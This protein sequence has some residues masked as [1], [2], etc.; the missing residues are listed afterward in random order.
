MLLFVFSIIIG[1][2][3]FLNYNDFDPD[4]NLIDHVMPTE[5]YGSLYYTVD[6]FNDEVSKDELVLVSY[7]IRSFNRNFDSFEAM[8]SSLNVYPNVIVLSET[9]LSDDVNMDGFK[10]FHTFRNDRRSGGV[11]VFCNESYNSEKLDEF[12]I[13]TDEVE[14][15]AIKFEINNTKHIILAIYR[16]HMGT[17]SNFNTRISEIISK[18]A[19]NDLIY[20]VGDLNINLLNLDY[21]EIVHFSTI[22][23]SFYLVPVI[24]EPTRFP[25]ASLNQTPS[26]LDHIWVPINSKISIKSGIIL[27]D[28]TDHCPTF[29]SFPYPKPGSAN[30]KIKLMFRDTNDTNMAIF[31]RAVRDDD[32]DALVPSS[33]D[34]VDNMTEKFIGRLNELYCLC[35]AIK[36]KYVG[37]KRFNKPWITNNNLQKIKEKSKAFKLFKAGLISDQENKSIR[38]RVNILVKHAKKDYFN[39]IFHRCSNDIG[40][41]WKNIRKIIASNKRCGISDISHNNFNYTNHEDISN[42]FSDYF[43]GISQQIDNS[44]PTADESPLR[45]VIPN[46]ISSLFLNPVSNAECSAIIKSLKNKK[47]NV[48]CVSVR[49]VKS[50]SD[51]VSIY[52]SRIVNKSFESGIFPNI[53]KQAIIVPIHKKGVH[54]DVGNYRPVSLL[55]FF[56]KILEKCIAVRLVGFLD[57]FSVLNPDQFGFRRGLSTSDALLDYM[58]FLYKNIDEKKHVISVFIDFSKAFDTVKHDILLSKLEMYG[59]RGVANDW[60]RSYLTGRSQRVRVGS[61]ISEEKLIINGVPQ[62][63]VLGPIL[64]LL[65]VNELPNI[66]PELKATLFADDTT[67]SAAQADIGNLVRTIDVGLDK[68]T[69]WA[70]ANRLA[71]NAQKNQCYSILKSHSIA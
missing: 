9:W 2:N 15:C 56:S 18:F 55:P 20:V 54:S 21:P 51:I 71:L 24:T 48:N 57:D 12:C 6:D 28:G 33:S 41:T 59:I 66:F 63:S 22:M 5:S 26:L 64:F 13:S 65:Y 1:T 25:P 29:I 3:E 58:E 4:L 14:S 52:F 16:P 30:D 8:L 45:Y 19:P 61:C 17:I 39:N 11:S 50:V 70:F 10:D 42:I 31:G 34:D 27:Y 40:K 69:A 35:F 36:I 7:N 49:A 62:G 67:L 46:I 44:I 37:A 68:F 53:F 32:W 47:T 38:N 43:S 23:R 60:F